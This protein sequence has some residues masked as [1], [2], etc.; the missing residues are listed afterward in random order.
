MELEPDTGAGDVIAVEGLRDLDDAAVPD[1][2]LRGLSAGLDEGPS[3]VV[4]GRGLAVGDVARVE[5]PFAD[6]ERVEHLQGVQLRD[7]G[8]G[9]VL[10]FPDRS[11]GLG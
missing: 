7:G 8:G 5:M 9:E 10:L 1:G 6:R 4:E 3:G 2:V 11:E